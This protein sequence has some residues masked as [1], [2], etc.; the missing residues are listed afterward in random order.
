MPADL[1]QQFLATRAPLVEIGDIERLRRAGKNEVGDL[2][3][4]HGP[5]VRVGLRV[6]A[7]PMTFAGP[8][9]PIIA[10]YKALP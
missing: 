8:T 7:S 5:I 4:V 3:I 2:E 9:S 6:D 1:F 10:G